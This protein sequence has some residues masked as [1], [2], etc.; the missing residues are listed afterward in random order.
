MIKI[1][2]I[3]KKAPTPIPHNSS[4]RLIIQPLVR[5]GIATIKT[6]ITPNNNAPAEVR[7]DPTKNNQLH[8]SAND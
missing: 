7:K 8:V 4:R 3:S 6:K 1:V 5:R 2:I